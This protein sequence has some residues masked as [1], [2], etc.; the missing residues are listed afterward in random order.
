MAKTGVLH[1]SF[2]EKS[3]LFLKMKLGVTNVTIFTFILLRKDRNVC[4]KNFIGG[5]VR[6]KTPWRGTG[7]FPLPPRA[8]F[9]EAY[10][11]AVD[12]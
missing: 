9:I 2:G 8:T 10:I 11:S 1:Y 6:G 12:Q 4:L 7:S 5:P 3:K